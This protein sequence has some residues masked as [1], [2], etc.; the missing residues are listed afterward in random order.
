MDDDARNGWNG[1]LRKYS[2]IPEL[3]NVLITFL[4]AARSEDYLKLLVLM[5]C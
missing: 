1:S 3:S 5:R 4:T 2:K